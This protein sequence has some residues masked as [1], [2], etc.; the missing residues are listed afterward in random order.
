MGI[1]PAPSAHKT[2]GNLFNLVGLMGMVWKQVERPTICKLLMFDLPS[3]CLH[4]GGRMLRQ[5][6]YFA[7]LLAAAA[8][9]FCMMLCWDSDDHKAPVLNEAT[10]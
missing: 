4:L 10:P 6:R 8:C 5:Y 2:S 7:G 1:L 3:P 9:T